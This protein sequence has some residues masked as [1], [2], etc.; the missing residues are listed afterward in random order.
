MEPLVN[1]LSRPL[2]AG[3][4]RSFLTRRDHSLF[5]EEAGIKIGKIDQC[6]KITEYPVP[7]ND[8]G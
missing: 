1:S 7:T 6:G 2:T 4:L 5:T 8:E 3:R